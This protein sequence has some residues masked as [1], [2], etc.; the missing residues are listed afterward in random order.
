V[1]K[2]TIVISE[3]DKIF[4]VNWIISVYMICTKKASLGSRKRDIFL[5][6][7]YFRIFRRA[8]EGNFGGVKWV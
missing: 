1:E 6:D 5:T 8:V 4:F 7:I 2:Y 3:K